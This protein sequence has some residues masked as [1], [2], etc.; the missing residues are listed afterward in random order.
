MGDG[1]VEAEIPGT[2]EAAM[3]SASSSPIIDEFAQASA[4]A[5]E[6][7]AAAAA[8]SATSSGASLVGV[9]GDNRV[10]VGG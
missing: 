6:W 5:A 10:K 3:A 2:T 4:T 9:R 7:A 1:G 8:A